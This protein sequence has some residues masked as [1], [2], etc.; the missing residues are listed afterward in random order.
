MHNALTPFRKYSDFSG[1]ASAREFWWFFALSVAV[2]VATVLLTGI[3]AQ[4]AAKATPT[5]A[6]VYVFW[7]AVTAVPWFALQVR[8]LHDQG[9]S[10]WLVSINIAGYAAL[11]IEPLVGIALLAISL[12]IMALRG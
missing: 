8:R 5:W 2:F 12:G 6:L 10:G 3:S 9:R 4:S 7:W 1:R 11:F